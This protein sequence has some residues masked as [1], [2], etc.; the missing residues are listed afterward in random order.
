MLGGHCGI[1]RAFLTPR[2]AK[3]AMKINDLDQRTAGN[4]T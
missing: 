4:A 1:P 3:Y 2:L